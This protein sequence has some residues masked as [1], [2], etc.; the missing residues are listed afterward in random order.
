MTRTNF[1]ITSLCIFAAHYTIATAASTVKDEQRHGNPV[2]MILTLQGTDRVVPGVDF[3]GRRFYF[4]IAQARDVGNIREEC[5]MDIRD[6]YMV[7]GDYH[8]RDHASILLTFTTE[9]ID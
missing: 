2:V 9:V 4:S 6:R 5:L 8:P 3:C 7:R 1:F